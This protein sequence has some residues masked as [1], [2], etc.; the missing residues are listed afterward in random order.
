MPRDFKIKTVFGAVDRISRPIGKIQK[1]IQKF[2]RRARR[3][4][5]RLNRVT[6]KLARGLGTVLRAGAIAAA[7]GLAVV[8]LAIKK[9]A[10]KMDNLAKQSRRLDF[11]IEALQ[12]WRFVAEQSGVETETFTTSLDRFARTVG[13]AKLGQGSLTT[14][15]K[16][17]NPQL[18]KQIKNTKS[19][20]EAF[21]LYISA[22]RNT[23]D[24]T[25]KAALGA[26][27]F[28][29][30]G[31]KMVN[32]AKLGAEEVAALR[33]EMQKNGVVTAQQALRAE[34]FN[35]AM[36]SLKLSLQGVMFEALGPIL[37]ILK[38]VM[39][40]FREWVVENKK[41]I[42]SKIKSFISG[43]IAGVKNL[44][45]NVTEFSKRVGLIEK[46]GTFFKTLGEII[47]F[48]VEN[49]KELS[50]VAG[51]VLGI[52]AAVKVLSAALTIVNL[53]MAANPIVL[54]VMGIVAA[55]ALAAGLIIANWEHVKGFF[56]EAGNVIASAWDAT[57]EAIKSLFNSSVGWIL[58]GPIKALIKGIELIIENWDGIKDFFANLWETVKEL[59]NSGIGWVIFG[60]I[61]A[62]IKAVKTVIEN[63]TEI[64]AFFV[65]LWDGVGSVFTAA[66]SMIKTFLG[67][68]WE[69]VKDLFDSSI[70]WIIFGPIKALVKAVQFIIENWDGIKKFF[71][72]TWN[73]IVNVFK[74]A[75]DKIKTF[76]G[77]LLSV[78]DKIKG[79]KDNLMGD[80]KVKIGIDAASV[81]PPKVET[82]MTGANA[83]G[84]VIPMF[85]NAGNSTGEQ[86]SRAPVQTFSQSDRTSRFFEE[87]NTSTTSRQELV[88]KD[89]SGRAVLSENTGGNISLER[90]GTFD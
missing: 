87:R 66:V 81:R 64:K 62:L 26:L 77:P 44:V 38:D 49:F 61:G 71:S 69:A 83:P 10:D 63:W 80:D 42:S 55:V 8:S 27:A 52:A 41:L 13:E 23:K 73:G 50:I 24:P 28:G 19:T 31:V 53:V 3:S 58:F 68:F 76:F 85:G 33:E 17:N 46:L 74:I 11:D 39:R 82:S 12:E 56:V 86:S 5:A 34:A 90:T 67:S 75:I 36:N 72:D 48:V 37:P 29:R 2:T 65:G 79:I 25:E 54:I 89:E 88:I 7:A 6:G 57:W 18:L 47:S 9:T 70:G 51:I 78:W 4:L 40:S 1:R 16:R 45:A 35:D 84:N 21:D 30:A 32:V 60:P 59:F 43:L 20:A 14:A 22:M 15:L